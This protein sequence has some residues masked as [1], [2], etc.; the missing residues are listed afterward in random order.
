MT[1]EL[2]VVRSFYNHFE[3]DVAKSALDAAGI[4]CLVRSDD[5]GGLEPGLWPGRG[6]QL[7]VRAEDARRAGEVLDAPARPA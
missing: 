1:D 5:A 3:A 2:V 4:D 7:L 6:V